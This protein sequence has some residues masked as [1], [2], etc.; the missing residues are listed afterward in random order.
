MNLVRKHITDLSP[1]QTRISKKV[2]GICLKDSRTLEDVFIKS[3][4]C[5]LNDC[6]AV[7]ARP[8]SS[9]P[10]T[11]TFKRSPFNS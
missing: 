9:T 2:Y 5:A 10:V 6:I 1:I 4:V 8:K 3:P 11:V 7:T